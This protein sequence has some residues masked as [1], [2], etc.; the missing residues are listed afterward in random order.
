MD[1]LLVLTLK[2]PKRRRGRGRCILLFYGLWMSGSLSISLS[3]DQVSELLDQG[4]S[5]LVQGE[6]AFVFMLLHL[7]LLCVLY[8]NILAVLLYSTVKTKHQKQ[9]DSSTCPSPSHSCPTTDIFLGEILPHKLSM[10]L[11]VNNHKIDFIGVTIR[12]LELCGTQF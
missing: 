9:K 12:T 3:F 11:F 4:V 8:W 6:K 7:K 1:I 2:G 10:Y 5:W